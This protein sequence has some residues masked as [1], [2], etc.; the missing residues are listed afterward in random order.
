M[1]STTHYGIGED[2]FSLGTLK[3][4]SLSGLHLCQIQRGE[5]ETQRHSWWSCLRKKSPVMNDQVK[6]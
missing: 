3:K 5:V 1:K 4:H 6:H 2:Y